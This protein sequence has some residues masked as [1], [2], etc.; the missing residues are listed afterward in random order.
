[1]LPPIKL[2]VPTKT[3][4]I[5]M[6]VLSLYDDDVTVGVS[7]N[8]GDDAIFGYDF[9]GPLSGRVLPE[10]S[11]KLPIATITGS[12]IPSELSVSMNF[13][14]TIGKQHSESDPIKKKV[15]PSGNSTQVQISGY[16][17]GDKKKEKPTTI[18]ILFQP[19]L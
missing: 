14:D 5:Y 9:N 17:Y 18:T 2:T 11:L 16:A 13:N 6:T 4:A 10:K 7:Y 12:T 19:T 1:M 15:G 8:L 3:K